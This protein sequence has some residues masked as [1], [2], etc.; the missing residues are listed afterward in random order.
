LLKVALNTI[1]Q[2]NKQTSND[3]GNKNIAKYLK[4][5]IATSHDS[6]ESYMKEFKS[7]SKGA[8]GN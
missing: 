5:S 4:N 8:M 3:Y 6:T 1:K 7:N 2:T